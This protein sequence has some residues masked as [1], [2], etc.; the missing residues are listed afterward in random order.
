MMTEDKEEITPVGKRQYKRGK[1]RRQDILTA[2]VMLL[3]NPKP[4]RFTTKEIAAL[5]GVSEACLY[6]HFSSKA[7][8]L[9]S[10]IGFCETSVMTMFSELDAVEGLT[11]T[12]RAP[13]R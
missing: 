11:Y 4:E 6:R 1:E 2:V 3:S 8:V 5:C 12:Q 9:M 13:P 7:E 10:L